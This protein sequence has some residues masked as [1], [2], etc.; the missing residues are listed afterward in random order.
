MSEMTDKNEIGLA[1]LSGTI[2]QVIYFNDD[3][4]YAINHRGHRDDF[5][6]KLWR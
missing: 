1:A 3:N 5:C 4:C 6:Q 2:E